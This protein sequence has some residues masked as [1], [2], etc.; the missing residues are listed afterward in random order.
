MPGTQETL[1]VPFLADGEAEAKNVSFPSLTAIRPGSSPEAPDLPCA[2]LGPSPPLLLL[3]RVA[4][5]TPLSDGD[6]APLS[7]T[8]LR[9]Q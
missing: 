8:A 7:L 1:A 5:T 6:V 4:G 9:T 3:P 2:P